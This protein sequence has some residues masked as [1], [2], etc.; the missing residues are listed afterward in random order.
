M[1]ELFLDYVMSVIVFCVLFDVRDGLKL[2]YCCIFYGL[3]E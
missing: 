2:V 3:N 1:C